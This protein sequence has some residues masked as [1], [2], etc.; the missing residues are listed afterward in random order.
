M[1]SVFSL[2]YDYGSYSDAGH[3]EL[4]FY[5]DKYDADLS[6]KFLEEVREHFSK[7]NYKFDWNCPIDKFLEDE[8]DSLRDKIF[9]RKPANDKRDI[10]N[11]THDN[12]QLDDFNNYRSVVQ[13]NWAL[14]LIKDI[15]PDIL[16]PVKMQLLALY[17]WDTRELNSFY[18]VELHPLPTLRKREPI[19]L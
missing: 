13:I 15:S 12:K 7:N 2:N 1:S 10:Y 9:A 19:C 17:P 3:V 14:N 5:H 6:C 16:E 4:G 18:V 8:Y 11:Y